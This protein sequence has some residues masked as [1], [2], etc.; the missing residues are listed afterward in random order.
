MA[1][2][3][4]FDLAAAATRIRRYRTHISRQEDASGGSNDSSF[5][6][7]TILLAFSRRQAQGAL[8]SQRFRILDSAGQHQIFSV[9][10]IP[11]A[12]QPLVCGDPLKSVQSEA[13]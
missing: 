5:Y 4:A 9:S 12:Y 13:V 11:Q 1:V 2:Q 10:P 3:A 8:R 6:D 7:H